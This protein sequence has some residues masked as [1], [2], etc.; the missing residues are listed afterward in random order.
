[1]IRRSMKNA[2]AQNETASAP[3]QS[4]KECAT[5]TS[6]PAR[7]ARNVSQTIQAGFGCLQLF[8]ELLTG[9][10]SNG[11][12]RLAATSSDVVSTEDSTPPGM[13][14]VERERHDAE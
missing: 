13:A 1:M 2:A 4:L 8:S 5:L 12:S 7:S 11:E 14:E 6:L 9:Q 3:A 10:G